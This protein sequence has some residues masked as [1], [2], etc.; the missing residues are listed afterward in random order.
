MNSPGSPGTAVR[1]GTPSNLNT[2]PLLVTK[3]SNDL[4]LGGGLRM[5]TVTAPLSTPVTVPRNLVGSVPSEILVS[6]MLPRTYL[7][8]ARASTATPGSTTHSASAV[9]KVLVMTNLLCA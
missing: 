3:I 9:F 7:Q 8:S 2:S 6:A 4:T 5:V 1:V